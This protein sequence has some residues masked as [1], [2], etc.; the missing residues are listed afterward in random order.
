MPKQLIHICV[1]GLTETINVIIQKKNTVVS[2]I[3]TVNKSLTDTCIAKKNV[4][5]WKQAKVFTFNRGEAKI[6]TKQYLHIF[7]DPVL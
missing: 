7:L 3:I 2:L 5:T 4:T 6:T 1:T